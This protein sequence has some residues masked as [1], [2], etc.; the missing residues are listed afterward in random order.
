[1]KKF[2]I[3]ILCVLTLSLTG[4]GDV[5]FKNKV[6]DDLYDDVLEDIIFKKNSLTIINETALALNL[7]IEE[8]FKIDLNDLFEENDTTVKKVV[9]YY[10]TLEITD[11]YTAYNMCIVYDLLDIDDSKLK[12][13]FLNPTYDNWGEL[14]VLKC[15]NMLDV[16]EELEEELELKIKNSFTIN[17]YNDAD[18]IGLKMMALGDD[19]PSVAKTMLKEYITY[20]GVLSADY[21]DYDANINYPGSANA[22]STAMTIIGLLACDENLSNYSVDGVSLY[23]MLLLFHKEDGFTSYDSIDYEYATPQA[24]L[25]LTCYYISETLNEEV[26]FF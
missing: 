14:T 15:L 25:A 22:C 23:D 19:T 2:L 16:N 5:E 9:D 18:V 17:D 12:S 20:S 13:Y 3:A 24:F 26:S 8:D 1:M 11:V 10:K 21:Y 6:L 7:L 4:C